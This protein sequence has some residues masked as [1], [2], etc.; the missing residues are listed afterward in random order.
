VVDDFRCAIEAKASGTIT[1]QHLEGLR[2]LQKDHP[3]V[4]QR[5]VVSLE[6]RP[7][8]TTDGISILPAR[9]FAL[10]L[11]RGELFA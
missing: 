5:I 10:A 2:E 11:A 1:D 9:D 3:E 8:K 4:E 6:M 7:S